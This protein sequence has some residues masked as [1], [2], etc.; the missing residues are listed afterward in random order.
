MF[1]LFYF[2]CFT[3]FLCHVCQSVFGSHYLGY[4]IYCGYLAAV[5][6]DG[7]VVGVGVGNLFILAIP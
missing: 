5:L 7:K 3:L 1:A 2:L 6:G 4:C